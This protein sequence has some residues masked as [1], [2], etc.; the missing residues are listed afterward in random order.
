MAGSPGFAVTDQL[1]IY[2]CAGDYPAAKWHLL[3]KQI[4]SQCG[5]MA[6]IC[7][8]PSQNCW[9][10][11]SLYIFFIEGHI[12]VAYLQEKTPHNTWLDHDLCISINIM[13]YRFMTIHVF[14]STN[15]TDH[16]GLS[17]APFRCVPVSGA[18]FGFSVLGAGHP[19]CSP[20]VRFLLRSLGIGGSRWCR[21]RRW[22][23][24]PG[25]CI[26]ILER[27]YIHICVVYMYIYIYGIWYNMVYVFSDS[28]C[29]YMLYNCIL[30]MCSIIEHVYTIML[31]Y[32]YTHIYICTG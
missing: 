32:I 4:H 31:L 24:T 1:N 5:E 12:V 2:I 7:H 11:W 18:R 21:L 14:Q 10:G 30:Y 16:H 19:C 15:I 6:S 23:R 28:L 9:P 8:S 26:T 17:G 22:P 25:G 27:I 29:V 13:A 20:W 3:L